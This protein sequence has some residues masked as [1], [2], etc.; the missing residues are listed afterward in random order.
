[1]KKFKLNVPINEERIK[2]LKV[3]DIVY[4]SGII[5]T[6]RDKAHIRILKFLEKRKE[7]PFKLKNSVI[8]HSGPIAKKEKNNFRIFSIGPTTSTRLNPYAKKI[9]KKFKIRAIIGKGGMSGEVV[10]AMKNSCVYLAMTGGCGAITTKQIKKIKNVYWEDLGLAEAVYELEVKNFG[11]LIV[12]IDSKGNS[13]YEKIT[14][15]TTGIEKF[16]CREQGIFT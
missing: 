15:T 2:E 12:A 9:I 10:K 1:M 8:L 16:E 13:L 7:L 4:I 11:P 14:K 5:F 6:A 3:A